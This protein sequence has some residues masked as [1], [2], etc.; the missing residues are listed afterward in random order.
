MKLIKAAVAA[1]LGL[2]FVSAFAE[3]AQ[4]AAVRKAIEPRLG[5]DAKVVAVS[6]TPYSGL[7]EVQVNGDIIYTDA[8]A[9]FLFV[10]R[11]VD[12]KTYQDYTKA[13]LEEINK[14]AFSDLPLELAMKQVKG[15]GKRVIAVFE[16]PNCG[17]CKRFRQTLE[18]IND[19]TVYTFM[20]NILSPDSIAK[21]RNV[22]CSADRNKAWDDWMLNGKAPA[23]A[24]DK[25]TTPH[26]KVLALGQR[27]GVTGTPTIIF[28]DG[29]RIPGAI[30]A[31]ALEVKLSSI[32]Q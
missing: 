19:I 11:I 26:E 12:T 10:G 3:T 7:F 1:L 30:D 13:R 32:K 17:Y 28:T 20:Y 15:N 24:S 6:K 23:P 29:S 31:K 8:K 18:G 14:V 22:W 25:C 5:E 4:E 16:D 21:S 9:Q 2:A 27:M